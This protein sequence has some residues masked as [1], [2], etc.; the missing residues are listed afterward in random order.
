MD[1]IYRVQLM[2]LMIQ[3]GFLI[4]IPLVFWGILFIEQPQDR[5]DLYLGIIFLTI[6]ANIALSWCWMCITNMGIKY[7]IV[8]EFNEKCEYIILNRT[9]PQTT[10]KGL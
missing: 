8:G 7:A 1:K 6:V 5:N 3:C 10:V 2:Q 9:T 4:F